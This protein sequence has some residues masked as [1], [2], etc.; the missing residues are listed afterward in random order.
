[1]SFREE[2]VNTELRY[3][4]FMFEND[5]NSRI[6]SETRTPQMKTYRRLTSVENIE[7]F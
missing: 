7:S 5:I 3:I 2:K 6:I 1:M 4:L